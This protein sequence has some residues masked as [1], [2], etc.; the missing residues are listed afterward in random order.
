LCYNLRGL[1]PAKFILSGKNLTMITGKFLSLICFVALVFFSAGCGSSS[2]STTPVTL[3]VSPQP[4]YIG[5]AQSMKFTAT[6]A[7]TWAVS[8]T[9]GASAGTIDAQ[10]NFTAPT[11]TQNTTVTVT[12]TSTSD[13]T[14]SASSTVFVIAPA[15]VVATANPQ[16]ALYTIF[17][18]DGISAQIQFGPDTTYGLSTWLVAAP[19]GGGAVP[20]LVA[21]MKGNTPYH[22]RAIFQPTGTT[23]TVFTD[24]DHTFTTT[25]YPAANLP[26]LTAATATGQTPQSGVELLA[27]LQFGTASSKLQTVVSDLDG[28]VLWAYDPG[29]AVPAGDV[30]NPIKLLPNGHFLIIYSSPQNDGANSV[31]QEIDL[32]G[33][34]FWQMTSAQLNAALAAATCSGCSITVTGTHHD[35]AL[36]PNGHTVFLT[37]VEKAISGTTV[38]GDAII[39]LDENHNPVWAWNAF[40]HLDVNR[41]PMA[42]PDWLHSN[43]IVYSPDDKALMV[44]M[45]HQAWILKI[46]YNDGAGDGSILWKLGYQ[47]DF[48]L[49]PGSTN[50]TSPGDW[51][52][53]QHDANII[54]SNTS[55]AIDILMFDNG[56]QR[57]LSSSGTLCG[58]TTTPCESRVPIYHVDESAKTADI[59]WID[60]LAPEFTAFGGSA[61]V[62]KNGN[63]EFDECTNVIPPANG[64]AIF[65]VTKTTPPTTVWSMQIAGQDAYRGFR[66]PSLYPGVQW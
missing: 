18:P 5:S 10:G 26:S 50:A 9:A 66:L 64:A 8:S 36:L 14:V 24:S 20:I 49:L 17:V 52:N 59:T 31:V 41:H 51:F 48:N 33:K 19:S 28:N 45:R 11:V 55:G 6:S 46:N 56:T 57:V 27:L 16:V 38:I 25:A 15:A 42:F 32:T 39:D 34:V 65:E 21:G 13:P 53:A 7:A 44:S 3:A 4:A 60:K 61:R 37:G 43:A 30:P 47:G 63:I 58:P 12:A 2:K 1:Q 22:M 40:D 29:S 35:F 62:L 23:N 54:S